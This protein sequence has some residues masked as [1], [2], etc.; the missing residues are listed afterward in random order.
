[1]DNRPM[2]HEESR[3]LQDR[4]DTRR[5]ADRLA[6]RL[7][8][9]AFNEDDRRFIESQ[10]LFF[11]ATTDADGFPDCSY[12]GGDPGFVRVIDDRTL[13]FPSYDGNGM[14]K[15]LGNIRANPAVGLLFVNFEE[16]ARLRVNGTATVSSDDVAMSLFPGAQLLVRVTPHHVFPNCPRY[17][18]RMQ[19]LEASPY[20]PRAECPAPI[21]DW[22]KRPQF[23][24]VLPVG[25][26]ARNDGGR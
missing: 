10:R 25:D 4:F 12:K 26:P 18:P 16:P 13:V 2:Y 7:L 20:V 1:M 19:M 22:K 8:R 6:E 21:P 3:N 24:E 23:Q 15:S 17:I 14:F 9:T 11:L 5:L